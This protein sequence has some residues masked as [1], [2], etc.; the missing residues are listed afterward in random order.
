MRPI[1]V[2]ALLIC[3]S[4]V[5]GGSGETGCLQT[6]RVERMGPNHRA[7]DDITPYS[8]DFGRPFAAST[9]VRDD[10]IEGR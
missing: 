5:L 7:H 1:A 8:K 10:S 3:F 9:P 2:G 6:L 4:A